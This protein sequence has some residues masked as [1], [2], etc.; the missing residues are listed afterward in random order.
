MVLLETSFWDVVWWILIIFL[1][2]IWFYLL[3]VI[4]ADLFSRDMS[5]W[6]KAAWVIGIIIFPFLGILIYLITRPKPTE[7]EV[8]EVAAA[9][10]RSAG[11]T[12]ADQLEKLS[13]LHDQGKLTDEEFAA[14]K[15]KLL[16]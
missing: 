12:T 5:G 1:F 10:A 15:A 4:F 2:A 11:I 13:A 16:A 9:E 8:A 3:I 7:A 6:A 14:Q